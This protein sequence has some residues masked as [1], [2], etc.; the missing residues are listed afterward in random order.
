[1]K[2]T[3]KQAKKV[4]D[5]ISSSESEHLTDEQL[6]LR[7]KALT[8]AAQ[9]FAKTL[10]KSALATRTEV[11][12][13]VIGR[14][15]DAV[16]FNWTDHARLCVALGDIRTR[17]GLLRILHD[18]VELRPQV[19]DH[20]SREIARAGKQWVA[21]LA[22]VFGGIVWLAGFSDKT[23]IAIDQAL[24]SDSS[25]SL[26]LLLD[27]ALRHN[28]PASIWSASLEAVSFQAC[29]KGAA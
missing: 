17:D 21:P 24:E 9:K 15:S 18:E 29:L 12:N 20:L 13:Q 2:N 3:T 1:M 4:S 28:V 22:T 6:E 5:P 14:L 25:Y 26:A 16:I 27:I 23:R 7:E 19:C 11:V 8:K 10:A